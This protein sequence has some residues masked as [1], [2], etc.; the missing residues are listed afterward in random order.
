[1]ALLLLAVMGASVGWFVATL[2]NERRAD[3]GYALATDLH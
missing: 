3:N 1:M 2:V